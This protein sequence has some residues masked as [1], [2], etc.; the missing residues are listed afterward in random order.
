MALL[1]FVVGLW[2]SEEDAVDEN[3]EH[4]AIIEQ[5]ERIIKTIVIKQPRVGL[6]HFKGANEYLLAEN[7][8]HGAYVKIKYFWPD[9]C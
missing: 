8:W 4:D 9:W 6:K 7:V 2:H 5:L 1:C 3:G